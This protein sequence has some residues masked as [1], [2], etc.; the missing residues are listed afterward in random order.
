MR[1]VLYL[2]V[3]LCLVGCN[4]TQY[5]GHPPHLVSGQLLVNGKPADNADIQLFPVE[6]WERAII[7]QGSTD[8]EGRFILSTFSMEDGAPTGEYEVAVSW[9]AYRHGKRF[10][11]DRLAGKL[12]NHK[13]SG[14]RVRIE[15]ST[16]ELPINLTATVLDIKDPDQQKGKQRAKGRR[17]DRD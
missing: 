17:E 16:S 5:Y 4:R 12:A 6:D 9:P 11:P 15:D 14:V 10:G 13:T 1:W 8:E 2:A 7:P 3:G